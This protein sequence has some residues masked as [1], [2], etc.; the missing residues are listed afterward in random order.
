MR[1]DRPYQIPLYITE[2]NVM[3]KTYDRDKLNEDLE[4]G[5]RGLYQDNGYFHVLVKEPVLENLDTHNNRMGMPVPVMGKSAGKAVK[6]TIPIE[7]GPQ[8]RM[9]T[10]KTASADPDKALAHRGGAL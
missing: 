2:I 4:V 5:V 1:H 8:F 10:L 7:E 9:G 3:H 6:V